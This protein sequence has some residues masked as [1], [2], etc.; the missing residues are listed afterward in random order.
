[1]NAGSW[2]PLRPPALAAKVGPGRYPFVSVRAGPDG[3]LEEV[4]LRLWNAGGEHEDSF[5][6]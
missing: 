4:E 3:R 6:G 1:M 5:P 2:A